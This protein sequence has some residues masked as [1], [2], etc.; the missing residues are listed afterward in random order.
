MGTI[1]VFI[2]MM[3]VIN[4]HFPLYPA[5]FLCFLGR[6][7]TRRRDSASFQSESS[8]MSPHFHHYSLPPLPSPA[9]HPS[10]NSSY[11]FHPFLAC[12]NRPRRRIW[13]SPTSTSQHN[14]TFSFVPDLLILSNPLKMTNSPSR[15]VR[16]AIL[17]EI[18]SDLRHCILLHHFLLPSYSR[19]SP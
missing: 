16:C 18:A 3:S 15:H 10:S 4:H 11:Y 12:R 6:A 19:S 1:E 9:P 13:P 2:K 7:S 17:A 5:A 14:W 8:L